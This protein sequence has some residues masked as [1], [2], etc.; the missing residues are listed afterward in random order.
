MQ[1]LRDWAAKLMEGMSE[2]TFWII[3]IGI[4]VV[5]IVVTTLVVGFKIKRQQE[6]VHAEYVLRHGGD[7]NETYES[8]EKKRER[9]YKRKGR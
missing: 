1:S 2:K 3:F 7:K 6:K 8:N 5:I 4:F 9:Q